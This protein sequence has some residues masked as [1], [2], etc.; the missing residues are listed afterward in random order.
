MEIWTFINTL[1][2]ISGTSA[3][4]IAAWAV[5]KISSAATTE[6]LNIINIKIA[7]LEEGKI[8]AVLEGQVTRLQSD[9][10]EVL[11]YIREERRIHRDHED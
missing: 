4:A 9:M 7:R 3:L 11:A 1:L 2:G 5:K 8:L 10:T 6:D